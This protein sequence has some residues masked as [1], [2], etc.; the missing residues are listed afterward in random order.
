MPP[1]PNQ[2]QKAFLL[3][4]HGEIAFI[5]INLPH[6]LNALSG[7][8]Y[9]ELALLLREVAVMQDITVTILTGNGKFFSAGA[10]VSSITDNNTEHLQKGPLRT[11]WLQKC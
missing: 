3:E 1:T 7:D 2:G 11:F 9:R 6:K 4:I 10:D 5:S 8:R